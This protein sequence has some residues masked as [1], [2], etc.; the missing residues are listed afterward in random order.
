[1]GELNR[2]FRLVVLATVAL[3]VCLITVIVI[4]YTTNRHRAQEGQEAHSALC[5]LRNDLNGRV[6]SGEEFLRHNPHGIDGISAS[7]IQLSLRN[8]RKTLQALEVLDCP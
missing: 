8:T 1:M 3:Y 4:L 6:K 7:D 2:S 5:V